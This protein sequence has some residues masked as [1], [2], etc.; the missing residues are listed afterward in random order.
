MDIRGMEIADL[1]SIQISQ[2][3]E[4][5]KKLN[6]GRQGEEIILLAFSRKS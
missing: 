1:N 6:E 5:E 2:L 4:A 3:Q